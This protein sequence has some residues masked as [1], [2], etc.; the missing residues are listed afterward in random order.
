MVERF[1]QAPTRSFSSITWLGKLRGNML[2]V[3]MHNC[4][5]MAVGSVTRAG[6]GAGAGTGGAGAGSSSSSSSCAS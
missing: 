4:R 5:T 2:S 6:G 3:P 1:T